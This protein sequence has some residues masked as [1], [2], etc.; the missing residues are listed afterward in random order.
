VAHAEPA[1]L[2]GGRA[3]VTIRG[4][5]LKLALV[6]AAV[7]L[8]APWLRWRAVTVVKPAGVEA[9]SVWDGSAVVQEYMGKGRPEGAP[10]VTVHVSPV[11]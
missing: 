5:L 4:L 8:T 2:I 3:L 6:Q 10:P 9:A 11:L 7:H 1:R